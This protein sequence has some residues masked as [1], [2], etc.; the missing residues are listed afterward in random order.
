MKEERL[1]NGM[2]KLSAD[3]GVIDTR[4]NVVY[5]EVICREADVKYFKANE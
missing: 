1:N 3:N 4:I 2:V 5:S